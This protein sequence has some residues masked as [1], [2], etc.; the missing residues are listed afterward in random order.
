MSYDYFLPKELIANI[1]ADPRDSARLLVYKTRTGE[2]I[3]D[4]FANIVRYLPDNSLL[5][6]NDTQ[7]IPARLE[8]TK[9]TGKKVKILFLVNELAD[10]TGDPRPV[11]KGLPDKRLDVGDKLLF[12][13][14]LVVEVISQNKEEFTFH[15]LIPKD[16]F[17]KILEDRG[18]T[19]LPPYIHSQIGEVE[20]RNK[21][22]TIFAEAKNLASVAAPTASLHFTEEV[23]R[24]LEQKNIEKAFV[25]LHVGRGTFSHVD[26]DTDRLHREPIYIS[27][28]SA[29]KIADA[30]RD[31]RT[32]IS[33]GTTAARV[34]ESSASFILD[35]NTADNL[36]GHTDLSG[37]TSIFIKPPYDFKMVDALITNFHLPNTSLLM[38]LDAFLQYKKSPKTWH[39]IYEYAVKNGFRFYSF[40]DAMLVI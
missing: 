4:I 1:P 27:S 14:H 12:D 37:S 6:L 36:E 33:S 8:L 3:E 10:S 23:F 38:L 18:L 2:I 16:S 19:P 17:R 5:V 7:V 35:D 15:L 39:E 40:G 30:K 24:S 31:G 28:K 20:L 13:G 22:Q 9:T 21:Y 34:L 32:I 26:E 29:K 11:V 25:T